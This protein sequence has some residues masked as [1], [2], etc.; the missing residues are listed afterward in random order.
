MDEHKLLRQREKAALAKA[1]IESEAFVEAMQEVDDALI[2]RLRE[3]P[4]PA[5]RDVL[6]Q[7]MQC[8]AQLPKVLKKTM[9][10]G[11]MAE[12]DLARIEQLAIPRAA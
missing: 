2:E 11:R 7:A 6:W 3:E 9:A 1:L 4:D 8:F 12:A 5:A 10:T